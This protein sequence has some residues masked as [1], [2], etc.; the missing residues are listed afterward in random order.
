MHSMVDGVRLYV[1]LPPPPALRAP[2]PW[3]GR[4]IYG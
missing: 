3:R 1:M 4:V 2:S